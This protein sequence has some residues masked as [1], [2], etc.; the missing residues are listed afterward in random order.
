MRT[1]IL[2]GPTRTAT[3]SLFR[4]FGR[5]KGVAPS[6]HKETDFFLSRLI[7]GID[8]PYDSYDAC[9]RDVAGAT[10]RIEASPLY[11]AFGKRAAEAIHAEEPDAHIVFTLREPTER[12][13]PPGP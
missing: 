7:E 13:S 10:A 1:C 3:T 2:A 9:F 5:T 6:I 12:F 4:Y 8:C 11:F